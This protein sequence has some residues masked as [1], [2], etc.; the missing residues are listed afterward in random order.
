MC[1][2]LLLVDVL[3]FL[4]IL[5]FVSHGMLCNFGAF[6]LVFEG[7]TVEFVLRISCCK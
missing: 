3:P 7:W 5:S 6:S 1:G 4:S 2:W